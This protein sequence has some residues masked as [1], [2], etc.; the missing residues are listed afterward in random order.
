MAV[1]RRSKIRQSA[2]NEDCSLRIHGLRLCSHSDTTVFAHAPCV[3]KG[4]GFKSPD[5]WGAYACHHCHDIIDGREQSGYSTLLP[6]DAAPHWMRGIYETQ[7]KLR[8]K[9]LL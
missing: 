2:R 6:D 3:D 8:E 4:T 1:N 7:K 9:G 5:W